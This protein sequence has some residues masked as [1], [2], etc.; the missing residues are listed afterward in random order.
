MLIT[1]YKEANQ[2]Q[3]AW[4]YFIAY[5]YRSYTTCAVWQSKYKVMTCISHVLHVFTIPRATVH[6]HQFSKFCM[7]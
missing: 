7:C 2:L 4:L 5:N 3:H 1:T 6:A